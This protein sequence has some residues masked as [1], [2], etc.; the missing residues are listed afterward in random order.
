MTGRR[1]FSRIGPPRTNMSCHISCIALTPP[2]R[3]VSRNL[4]MPAMPVSVEL[5]GARG[6]NYGD[7]I[8]GARHEL[9]ADGKIFVGEAARDGKGGEAAQISD[10]AERIGIVEPG[11]E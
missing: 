10:A 7:V 5:I 1:I 2:G 6:L 11:F 4:R 3:R 9:Q 8:A